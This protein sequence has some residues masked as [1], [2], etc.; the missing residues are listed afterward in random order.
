MFIKIQASVNSLLFPRFQ[1]IQQPREH[2]ETAERADD[3]VKRLEPETGNEA[4]TRLNETK[5]KIKNFPEKCELTKN[6]KTVKGC[7]MNF[8]PSE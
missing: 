8:F 2:P 5:E 4:E 7:Q 6:A 1:Q 3:D